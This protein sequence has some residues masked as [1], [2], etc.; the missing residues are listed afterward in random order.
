MKTNCWH[1]FLTL[2]IFLF[3][4]VFPGTAQDVGKITLSG[5]VVDATDGEPLPGAMIKTG[6]GSN[7]SLSDAD[8]KFSIKLPAGKHKI[9]VVYVGYVPFS[10]EIDL[11]C[12][13]SKTVPLKRD[14]TTLKEVTVTAS[15][16]RGI[17]SSS[18]IDRSA[19]EHLQPTSFTDLLEL[20]PGNISKNPDLSSVNTIALR[21]TGTKDA[22]GNTVSNN[23]YATSALGTLFL[24]DGAPVNNDANLQSEGLPG[25]DSMSPASS[26]TSV[27]KGV[28][29]RGISTDNLESVEIIRG[30][31]SAEY[32]NL[33]SGVVKIKRIRNA[34]PLTLRFKADEFSKLISVGK[35]VEL[36]K[37]GQVLNAD[38]GYLDA[39]ADP[40]D[41]M[42]NYKRLNGSLR[43]NMKFRI[44]DFLAHWNLSFDYTGSFDNSKT[45]PDLNFR[46]ID[47]FKSTYNRYA[48]TSNLTV[49]MP[50][51]FIFNKLA[52]D[53]SI[54][55]ESDQLR[56]RKQVA[57]TRAMLAPTSTEAGE[58]I[59]QYLFEEYIA[60]YLCD[61]KPFVGFT[62]ARVSGTRSAGSVTFDYKSG[63]EWSVTKNY[64]KGQVYDLTKPLS[65]GWSSRP[66]PYKDIPALH[67]LSFFAENRSV[68]PL[69]SSTL[70]VQLGLR[71]IQLLS[72]D[73]KYYLQGRLYI[74]PRINL[75]WRSRDYYLDKFCC[76]IYVGAGFGKTTKMPT[77]DLLYPLAEYNDILQLNYYDAI[78]P[79]EHSLASVMTY[80]NEATNYDLRPARNNKWE[81]N[82]GFKFG[83]FSFTLS[84]FREDMKDGFRYSAIYAPFSYKKYD[85]SYINSPT[86]EGPPDLSSLPFEET[87]ILRGYRKASN[88][89]RILKEGVE[90]TL[91]TSRWE[92]LHTALYI[93]GAWLKSTYTN[94]Q[95]LYS[96]VSDIVDGVPVSDRYV[97]LYDYRDGS[98]NRQFNTNFMF[99]TQIPRWKLIFTANFQCMWYVKTRRLEQ[100]GTPV[101]YLATDGLLHPFD[102]EAMN[103]PVLRF[104]IKKYN[105]NNF[106]TQT[107]P[108]A[109]Y[110]NLKATKQIGKILRVAIFV[111]RLI[112]FLPDFVSNGLV[113]RRSSSSYFGMELNLTL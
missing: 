11:K 90:F 45:D 66:R 104:L 105:N 54:S 98:V 102:E 79:K 40:R 5:C 41:V 92:A 108:F 89:S 61:G 83:G 76:N 25:S 20:L 16:G 82:G 48:L 56:R 94:S 110:L 65:P 59:G 73:N 55:Y 69:G 13:S 67:V 35:G 47:E 38:F 97:G 44:S 12:N 84:L 72:L 96:P 49:T 43:Y 58:H 91:G 8:G 77:V 10:T 3:E 50:Q 33:T 60:D 80:I 57:P 37:W 34:T 24:I 63:L 28:D 30:I 113:V 18:I 85:A 36:N 68:L 103:D 42:V 99:D 27:N 109:G 6:G 62:K 26:L 1:I 111:N 19:M 87:A 95:M 88:G 22:Y 51:S 7:V 93:S 81:I 31:P 23:N 46:K 17:S 100:N 14:A 75:Q 39:K 86:L 2:F 29:M 64:G 70:E 78:N 15:E 107:V 101:S 112:D 71:T 32:G 9:Y 21:E 74:D 52:L 53:N 106:K 4:G